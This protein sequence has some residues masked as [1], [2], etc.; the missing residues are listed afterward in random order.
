MIWTQALHLSVFNALKKSDGMAKMLAKYPSLTVATTPVSQ[1]DA[2]FPVLVIQM[3]E[4]PEA[5]QD[6]EN[7]EVNAITATFQVD[8]VDNKRTRERVDDIMD[9]VLASAK[10]LRMSLRVMQNMDTQDEKRSV[11]R[12]TRT[13]TENDIA[14]LLGGGE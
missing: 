2:S 13:F 4:S 9:A 1:T 11:A 3:L 12:L 7:D 14:K 10:A 6:L 5:A 8:V